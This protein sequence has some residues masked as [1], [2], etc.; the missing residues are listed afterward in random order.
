M[1]PG[2]HLDKGKPVVR[3]GR[4]ATGLYP[5]ELAGLPKE[6]DVFMFSPVR[7]SWSVLF[8]MVTVALSAL[9]AA[10]Q[11]ASSTVTIAVPS[12]QKVEGTTS[13]VV[14]AGAPLQQA[15]L[16]VKSNIAW[17]LVAHVS[18]PN[19][20]IAWRIA[21]SATWQRLGAATPV[22]RGLKGVHQVEYEVQPDGGSAKQGLPVAVTFSVEPV[23]AP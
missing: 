13:L 22:L 21:G 5:V 18:D 3:R 12:I 10:A 14:P 8:I 6:E 23:G 20:V 2:P 1:R 17:V 15:Q 9:P 11:T 4:K 16:V 7:A 19:A